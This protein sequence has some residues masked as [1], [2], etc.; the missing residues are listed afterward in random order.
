[1]RGHNAFIGVTLEEE[2]ASNE[3][4]LRIHV[5]SVNLWRGE[6]D[7]QDALTVLKRLK[8]HGHRGSYILR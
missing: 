6:P 1:V 8:G 4:A 2:L 3:V 7:C 5:E